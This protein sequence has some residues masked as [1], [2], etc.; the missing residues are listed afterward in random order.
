MK[1]TGVYHRLCIDLEILREL[2]GIDGVLT[3]VET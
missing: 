3:L 2:A 1:K